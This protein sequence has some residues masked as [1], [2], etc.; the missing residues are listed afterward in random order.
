MGRRQ[1]FDVAVSVF[2]GYR[3]DGSRP[4]HLRRIRAAQGQNMAV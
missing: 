4:A 1:P 2:S 3:D